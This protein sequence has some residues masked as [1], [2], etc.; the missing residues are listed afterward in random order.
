MVRYLELPEKV[1][2]DLKMLDAL[3]RGDVFSEE[4]VTMAGDYYPALVLAYFSKKAT[5][6][7]KEVTE[8]RADI[9]EVKH[10]IYA[11]EKDKV[12]SAVSASLLRIFNKWKQE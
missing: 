1:G 10:T 7:M 12:I 3:I 8:G 11:R 9:D 4:A 5:D 6:I 2:E